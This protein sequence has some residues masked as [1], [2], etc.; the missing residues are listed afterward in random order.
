MLIRV[1]VG[2]L[3]TLLAAC[4][5]PA[6]PANVACSPDGACPLG[7]TCDLARNV[8]VVPGVAD[9]AVDV[10]VVSDGS[11]DVPIDAAPLG[12]WGA[13]QPLTTV[14]TTS[15]ET[16]PGISADGLELVFGSTRPT[17]AGL[18]DL[19]YTRRSSLGEPFQA[20]GH[21]VHVG[22]QQIV[23]EAGQIGGRVVAAKGGGHHDQAAC[24]TD[25]RQLARAPLVAAA[26][27]GRVNDFQ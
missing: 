20:A 5:Q 1:A 11:I 21:Q 24:L 12:P 13:A 2:G 7:Q 14:N 23:L 17:G 18:S 3:G 25:Q 27:A 15:I 22:Q 26:Q 9:G 8:C 10:A 6:V 4:Y 19:Y 16:D